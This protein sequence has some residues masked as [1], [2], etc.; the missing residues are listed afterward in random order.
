MS[1]ERIDL[2]Q[3]LSPAVRAKL[4]WPRKIW[5]LSICDGCLVGDR[6]GQ[7]A[8]RFG[9]RMQRSLIEGPDRDGVLDQ[10]LHY[11]ETQRQFWPLAGPPQPN[12]EAS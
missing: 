5:L 12:W 10:A 4:D 2:S 11:L 1:E 7:W 3:I 8:V 6:N 9:R